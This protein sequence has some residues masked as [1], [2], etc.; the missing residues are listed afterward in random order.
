M[1][2]SLEKMLGATGSALN[3][4]LRALSSNIQIP[5]DVPELNITDLVATAMADFDRNKPSSE[6]I[7]GEINKSISAF[8]TTLELG[9]AT[10]FKGFNSTTLESDFASNMTEF[11][12]RM[13][14]LNNV[15]LYESMKKMIEDFKDSLRKND[16]NVSS[17]L[18][19]AAVLANYRQDGGWYTKDMGW[20]FGGV[21]GF[22]AY[23]RADVDGIMNR[24]MKEAGMTLMSGEE[25][26][27][28][29]QNGREVDVKLFFEVQTMAL[30]QA[31]KIVAG[32]KGKKGL[33]GEWVG[34]APEY[35]SD[36][37]E[38]NQ[39][40]GELG[41][42]TSG[43]MDNKK[44]Y[45]GLNKE[46]KRLG[47]VQG[48]WTTAMNITASVVAAA[49]GNVALMMQIG[50]A[51]A[52]ATTGTAIS[53]GRDP[54]GS[55][56]IG[57]MDFGISVGGAMVGG[58]W[59]GAAIR[60]SAGV[61]RAGIGQNADGTLNLDFKGNWTKNGAGASAVFSGV[62]NTL[63]TGIGDK[64]GGKL[65][66]AI[67]AG[68]DA[69]GDGMRFNGSGGIG[70]F[71]FASAMGSLA[72]SAASYGFNN[73]SS[74]AGSRFEGDFGRQML[75]SELGKVANMVTTTV[76]GNALNDSRAF[77][78]GLNMYQQVNGWSMMGGVLGRQLKAGMDARAAQPTSGEGSAGGGAEG[79]FVGGIMVQGTRRREW[80][81]EVGDVLSD[82]G[83]V[84]G[85]AAKDFGHRVVDGLDSLTFGGST[86]LGNILKEQVGQRLSNFLEGDGLSTD[87]Q[88]VAKYLETFGPTIVADKD[89]PG[90]KF[91]DKDRA[92]AA[93]KLEKKGIKLGSVSSLPDHVIKN[94]VD[95][96]DKLAEI[97]DKVSSKYG[98]EIG[99]DVVGALFMNE[100]KK[101]EKIKAKNG[102]AVPGTDGLG[103]INST[104]SAIYMS[105]KR[106]ASDLVKADANSGE[107]N[108]LWEGPNGLVQRNVTYKIEDDKYVD[109]KDADGKVIE[110]K[111]VQKRYLKVGATD[112][113]VTPFGIIQ[114][115]GSY[116]PPGDTTS[117]I[118]FEGVNFSKNKSG[119]WSGVFTHAQNPNTDTDV[120]PSG[121]VSYR[122]PRPDDSV[123]YGPDKAASKAAMPLITALFNYFGTGGDSSKLPLMNLFPE[124][125]IAHDG[126]LLNEAVS[127]KGGESVGNQLMRNAEGHTW[128]PFLGIR[129]S[130]GKVR[131]TKINNSDIETRNLL[132][133]YG[134]IILP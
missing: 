61:I 133:K 79:N 68:M 16:D 59:A 95:E 71:S 130:S 107:M 15:K 13:T 116:A 90:L 2:Q 34:Q 66:F 88:V 69:I 33:Y 87:K 6:R 9:N 113:D 22:S 35:N 134:G 104:G 78:S 51:Q 124:K 121:G 38:S 131:F 118:W 19:G 86:K 123:F 125:D 46:E 81:D 84:I 53:Q 75:S 1:E 128:L 41:G 4:R 76:L 83:Q 129:S 108:L 30:E 65:G 115:S 112:D 20:A 67:S 101:T 3:D 18:T 14:I 60:G 114:A 27:A 72:S 91:T 94:M 109:I 11:S 89:K 106:I 8:N 23:Q 50:A 39:G 62:M 126:Q 24:G 73:S 97:Y 117:N 63:G 32:D 102:S 96:Y 29:L 110:R 85:G 98:E 47:M 77:N 58:D 57:L 31:F 40:S 17:A 105:K 25:M 82:A 10:H 132:N 26:V 45:R 48:A 64:V 54:G 119:Q 103:D 36:G 99:Q 49:S 93:A 42:W 80:Y 52:T 122:E 28:F 100:L 43:Q 92:D 56:A 55:I 21:Y 7:F 37:D 12:K 5:V 111:L 70:G 120:H 74:T 127:R 44:T